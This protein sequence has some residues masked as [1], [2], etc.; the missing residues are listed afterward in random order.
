MIEPAIGDMRDR[1]PVDGMLE[2][3]GPDAERVKRQRN[4]G[5]TAEVSRDQCDRASDLADARDENDLSRERHPRRRDLEQDAGDYTW[6]AAAVG[7]NA[8]AGYQ[9]ATEE[10]VMAIGGFNGSD[11]S[12]TLAEFQQYVADG[13]IH[14][15]IGGSGLGP[16]A[17]GSDASGEIAAWV[18]ANFDAQT[19]D[20]VTVYDLSTGATS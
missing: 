11:P 19:V 10:P 8:A 1:D 5:R 6:V 12:P 2:I 14:W 3:R 13:D 9:L 17:G 4:A 16:S 20:G 18:A 7:S 15:F